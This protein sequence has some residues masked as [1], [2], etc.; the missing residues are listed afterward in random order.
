MLRVL[1]CTLKD[2]GSCQLFIPSRHLGSLSFLSRSLT[3]LPDNQSQSLKFFHMLE[4]K[5]QMVAFV[6]HILLFENIQSDIVSYIPQNK[7]KR[8]NSDILMW[9]VERSKNLSKVDDKNKELFG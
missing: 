6:L 9:L 1:N 4:C 8:P 3:L 7:R 5:G 2:R